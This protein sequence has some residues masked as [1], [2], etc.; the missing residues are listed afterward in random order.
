MTVFG[1][2]TAIFA[3]FGRRKRRVTWKT[4]GM[5]KNFEPRELFEAEIK[6]GTLCVLT[7][8]GQATVK[9]AWLGRRKRRLTWKM[10]GMKKVCA[11]RT[12]CSPN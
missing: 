12:F 2:A 9:F 4:A 10:A 8:F 6:L 3:W 1:Q 11:A 5:K 7:V